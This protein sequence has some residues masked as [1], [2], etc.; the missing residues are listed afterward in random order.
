[1]MANFGG[2]RRAEKRVRL[3]LVFLA[4]SALYPGVWALFAPESFFRDFPGFGLSWIQDFPPYNE[5]LARDVGAFFLAFGV[6]FL[7]AAVIMDRRLTQVV[8]SVSLVFA[9]PHLIFHLGDSDVLQTLALGSTVLVALLLIPWSR[10][11]ARRSA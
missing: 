11:A 3:G 10:R 1:M 4:V 7:A 8:L 5:H 6:L 2:R 9:V